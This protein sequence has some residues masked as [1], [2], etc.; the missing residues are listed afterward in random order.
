MN[1][2]L[3][4][5]SLELFPKEDV[6]DFF[7]P[8]NKELSSDCF[9]LWLEVIASAVVKDRSIV[10]GIDDEGRCTGNGRAISISDG[11][12]DDDRAVEVLIRRIG[13]GIGR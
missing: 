5:N 1:F 11:V 13:P 6:C 9:Y 12:V 4:A 7:V 8:I 10:D 3:I 2:L